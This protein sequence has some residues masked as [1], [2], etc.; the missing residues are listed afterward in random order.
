MRKPIGFYIIA[1]AALGVPSYLLWREL[2]ESD[3]KPHK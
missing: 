2:T 3:S 1:T